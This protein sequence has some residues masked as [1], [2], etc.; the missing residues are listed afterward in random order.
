MTTLYAA[1]EGSPRSPLGFLQL[2]LVNG[3]SGLV[4]R[5][6]VTRATFTG[7]VEKSSARRSDLR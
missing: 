4:Q 3:Q 1:A 7:F 5:L 6:V 2:G